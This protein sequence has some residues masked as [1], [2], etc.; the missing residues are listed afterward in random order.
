MKSKGMSHE[1]CLICLMSGL[2][3]SFLADSHLDMLLTRP[4]LHFKHFKRHFHRSPLVALGNRSVP[5]P[6]SPE[7]VAARR[8]LCAKS[9]EQRHH[10]APTGM[11]GN[12]VVDH[13]CS[14]KKTPCW[15]GKK[16][17]II[18]HNSIVYMVNIYIYI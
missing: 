14:P 17:H 12:L 1:P 7:A 13:H 6:P 2:S 15:F 9:E 4:E 10:G 5:K 8:A 16:I 11:I 3:S 18:Y